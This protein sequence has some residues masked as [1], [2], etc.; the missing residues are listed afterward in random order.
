MARTKNTDRK[1]EGSG[2]KRAT[3]SPTRDTQGE[4][5]E[6][7]KAIKK[8]KRTGGVYPV[9]SK[10]F[11]QVENMRRHM[12]TRHQLNPDGS[13]IDAEHQAKYKACNEC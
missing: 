11:A 8:R 3:K 2:L 4:P 7:M 12:G 9:C 6:T 13:P 1:T 5:K 10:A